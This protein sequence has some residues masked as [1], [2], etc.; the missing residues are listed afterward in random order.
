MTSFSIPFMMKHHILALCSIALLGAGSAAALAHPKSEYELL[1]SLPP[2]LIP[3]LMLGEP[4]E[5]GLIGYHR[6][7]GQWYQAGMQRAGCRHLLGGVIADDVARMELAWTSIDATFARQVEDGGFLSLPKPYGDPHN[8][9]DRV[10]T[11]YF[12][13]QAL[14]NALLVLQDSPHE[15]LFHD[16]VEALKPRIGRAC[17]FVMSGYDGIVKQ[18]G[19][20]ANRLFI[21]AKAL[22]LCGVLLDEE[23]YREAARG[24]VDVALPLRDEEGVFIERGGRDSSYNAVSILMAQVVALYLPDPRIDAAMK[25][26]MV[27]QRTRIEPTG[28]V[29]IE[30][31]TRTGLGQEQSRGEGIKKV[32][33]REVAVALCYHAVMYDDPGLL[34]VAQDVAAW[35]ARSGD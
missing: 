31:N 20:T 13:L 3:S 10:E 21:A 27:W 17:D 1:R 9:D 16:R 32:N 8:F 33:Y 34:D 15:P 11:A 12:Y 25:Q 6:Q 26:A 7:Q 24:L 23:R 18:V 2:G 35:R 14:A 4:D 19:H 30:G 29:L 28:E 22:G 5:N